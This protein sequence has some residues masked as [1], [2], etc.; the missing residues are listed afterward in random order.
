MSNDRFRRRIVAA[1]LMLSSAGCARTNSPQNDSQT[2]WLREC[3]SDRD[4]GSLSCICGV[5]SRLCDDD[6]SCATAGKTAFCGQ[7]SQL[8]S[9]STCRPKSKPPALCLIGCGKDAE[10]AQANGSLACDDGVCLPREAPAP[11]ALDAGADSGQTAQGTPDSSLTDSSTTSMDAGSSTDAALPDASLMD[12]STTSMDSS[13]PRIDAGTMTDA[14]SASDA[15]LADGSTTMIDAGLQLPLSLDCDAANANHWPI[16]ATHVASIDTLA[17][18]ASRDGLLIGTNKFPEEFWRVTRPSETV[19]KLNLNVGGGVA[20]PALVFDG[21]E[22]FI[23]ANYTSNETVAK[24]N[25]SDLSVLN[26]AIRSGGYV[27]QL[28]V[29]G[30]NVYWT[31]TD[32]AGS[33]SIF[34]SDRNPGITDTLW[35]GPVQGFQLMGAVLYF[36]AYENYHSQLYRIPKDLSAAAQPLG[37]PVVGL[38]D[39]ISDGTRLYAGLSGTT[40]QLGNRVGEH[41]VAQVNLTDGS[42]TPFFQVTNGPRPLIVDSAYLYWLTNYQAQAPGSLWAGMSNGAGTPVEIARGGQLS[43]L[44]QDATSVY[45]ALDCNSTNHIIAVEKQLIASVVDITESDAGF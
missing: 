22:L 26:L 3:S 9:A 34:R 32:A 10:C 24:L 16:G 38:N 37:L 27:G 6:S 40:D 12:S 29:D 19:E 44:V 28:I 35:Q 42:L 14:A 23:G 43:Q 5:C 31:S 1:I 33:G 8:K 13:I 11:A 25:L 15:S 20:F 45:I 17:R 36:T 4:C 7:A 18:F 39:L 2:H 30:A 21:P 41:E